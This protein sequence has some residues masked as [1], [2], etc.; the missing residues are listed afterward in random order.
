MKKFVL[1]LVVL[2]AAGA[3]VSCS[4]KDAAESA[5]AVK[6]KIENCTNPDSLSLYVEQAK[7]YADKLVKEGKIDE[8]QKYLETIEPV[9]KEKAPALAGTF[10]AVNAALGKVK[11]VAGD[12]V[13][14]AKEAADNAADSLKNAADNAVE[15]AK[16]AAADAVNDAKDKANA[17][18][19]AAAQ[20]VSDAANNAA[21]KVSDAASNAAQKADNKVKDLLNK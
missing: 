7:D 2:V 9:V 8:A 16:D 5:D 10:D 18:A 12:T 3:A 17:A 15:G 11:D 19:D 14:S 21:Q 4:K 20:K 13:D 1:A 6:S